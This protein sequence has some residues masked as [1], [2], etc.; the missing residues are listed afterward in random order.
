VLLTDDAPQRGKTG[1]TE[2]WEIVETAA[3]DA[4]RI[5]EREST[6]VARGAGQ[7]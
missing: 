5:V 1:G 4:S 3:N 6:G 2:S 7:V